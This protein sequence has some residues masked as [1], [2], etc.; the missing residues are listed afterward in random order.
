MTL[1]SYYTYADIH[2]LL[3][4]SLFLNILYNKYNLSVPVSWSNLGVVWKLFTILWF[5]FDDGSKIEINITQIS[6]PVSAILDLKF[7]CSYHRNSFVTVHKAEIVIGT[8]ILASPRILYVSSFTILCPSI[9]PL[10][11]IFSS[12]GASAHLFSLHFLRRPLLT[13]I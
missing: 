9:H 2:D 3:I 6:R 5:A 12:F 7:G 10:W 11:V 13:P 8:D 1:D 4:F